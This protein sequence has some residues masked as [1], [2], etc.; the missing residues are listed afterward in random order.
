MKRYNG[1]DIESCEDG[2]LVYYADHL[3]EIEHALM[4]S[5]SEIID[6]REKVK[7][8]RF[9]IFGLCLCLIIMPCLFALSIIF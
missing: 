6:L 2:D 5:A 4:E 7:L 3:E 9:T 1:W 8:M